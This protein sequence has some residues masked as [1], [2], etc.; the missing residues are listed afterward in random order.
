M[1]T[2][3]FCQNPPNLCLP[4]M[5]FPKSTDLRV[6]FCFD[7]GGIINI[8]EWTFWL[9]PVDRSSFCSLLA[10]LC[11]LDCR[12][13]WNIDPLTTIFFYWKMKVVTFI[14]EFVVTKNLHEATLQAYPNPNHFYNLH[15]KG[16]NTHSVLVIACLILLVAKLS[17]ATIEHRLLWALS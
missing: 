8:Q 3:P 9:F 17:D 10:A 12:T 13:S 4:P 2:S 1:L 15:L 11:A 14:H 6:R 7:K 16:A 5:P